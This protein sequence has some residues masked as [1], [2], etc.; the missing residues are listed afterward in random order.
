MEQQSELQKQV[1]EE[2]LKASWLASYRRFENEVKGV[3]KV[4]KVAPRNGAKSFA[5]YNMTKGQ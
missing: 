3:K 5:M 2:K 1:K 4:C